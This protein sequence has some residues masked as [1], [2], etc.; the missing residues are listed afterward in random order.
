[1][2]KYITTTT[3]FDTFRIERL[4]AQGLH[5]DPEA[6]HHRDHIER[7]W[8][9]MVI[10][11]SS[12]T[13]LLDRLMSPNLLARLWYRNAILSV[14]V[15]SIGCWDVLNNIVILRRGSLP[16]RISFENIIKSTCTRGTYRRRG[17]G[18]RWKVTII[19]WR[20]YSR[21]E[22]DRPDT[23]RSLHGATSAFIISRSG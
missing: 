8:E 17:R 13:H 12:H 18:L 3:A 23:Y 16:R 7:L 22:Q 15:F 11:I 5:V 1:M 9:T 21:V 4:L 2:W 14:T 19:V 6:R 10:S 20:W